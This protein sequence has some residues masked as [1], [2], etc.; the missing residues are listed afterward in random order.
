MPL[1]IAFLGLCILFQPMASHAFP[2]TIEVD[3]GDGWRRFFGN[4]SYIERAIESV[5]DSCK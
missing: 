5:A 4:N 3:A 1:A 2:D